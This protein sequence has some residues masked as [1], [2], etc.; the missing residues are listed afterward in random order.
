MYKGSQFV[1]TELLK[2]WKLFSSLFIWE[3][4]ISAGF[5]SFITVTTYFLRS[6]M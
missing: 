3:V 6:R 4:I 1:L 5:M 2:I